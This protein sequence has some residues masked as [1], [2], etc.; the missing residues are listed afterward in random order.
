MSLYGRIFPIEQI[1]KDMPSLEALVD[2]LPFGFNE[3]NRLH[4]L[5]NEATLRQ[6]LAAWLSLRDLSEFLSLT[7]P[8]TV[9]RTDLG[10][11]YFPE[12]ILPNFNLSHTQTVSVAV[13]NTE[14][15]VGVD[16]ES[17]QKIR[18]NKD[19]EKI[20]HR[21]FSESEQKLLKN[22]DTPNDVFLQIWTKKEALAKLTGEGLVS[23]IGKNSIL[24][25]PEIQSFRLQIDA[26]VAYLT[27]AT[28]QVSE[29]IQWI[30]LTDSIQIHEI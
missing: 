7:A 21:F 16:V 20:A 19:L 26:D 28:N 8:L 25:K 9:L 11:P 12:P 24:P 17:L 29:P 14:R 15:D 4:S 1:P 22:T 30:G 27:V 2:S 10:K 6:S 5:R 18:I 3:K 13:V 23:V